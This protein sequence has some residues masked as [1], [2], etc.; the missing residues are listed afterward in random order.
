M[1][2]LEVDDLHV[3]FQTPDGVVEAVRGLS[4]EVDDGQTLAIVGESGSGKSVATQTITGLTRG[5][6][7]SG[8]ARFKGTDLLHCSTEQLR[9]IRGAGIGMIFQDP[10]SSLHPYYRVGWQ[11]VEMIRAH[12][13]TVT[14]AQAR[15][16]AVELLGLVGIPAPENRVDD[17]PHQFSGGMRQRVMI[18][19]AMAL[20]PALLI[21]DEPTTALDVTVQEQ[22]L[23]VMGRLQEEFGTA[24]VLITHDLGIVAELS[25]EVVVMYAGTAMER[26]SRRTIFYEHHHPYTEGLLGSL[27]RT[28]GT[29][30]RLTPIPGLPP[31]LIGLP[32]ACPF[33]P[34]CGYAWSRCHEQAPP[35]SPV[36]SDPHHLS[37]CWLPGQRDER[38]QARRRTQTGS[39]VR[40]A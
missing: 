3:S 23:S 1:A 4:F 6:T 22:V 24:I 20:N 37:A 18:A 29:R 17:Y 40:A 27:P 5:A 31:S 38:A 35:L 7:V 28:G 34:R 19:M 39:G 21:A 8:R 25:D 32:D 9:Q 36:Y 30:E 15:R 13:R 16:R 2:L 11:I 26:A 14:K 10:L 12:D 33:A